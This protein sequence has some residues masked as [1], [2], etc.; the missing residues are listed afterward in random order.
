M[1]CRSV[2]HGLGIVPHEQV[3]GTFVPTKLHKA[4]EI[5]GNNNNWPPPSM[6]QITMPPA[7]D[8]YTIQVGDAADCY[9]PICSDLQ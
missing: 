7:L 2:S 5:I 4:L 3:D 1:L 6:D 8:G 9:E